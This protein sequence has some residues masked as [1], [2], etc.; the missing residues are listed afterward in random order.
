MFFHFFREDKKL[1]LDTIKSYLISQ[2]VIFGDSNRK[3]KLTGIS[4]IEGEA[5]IAVVRGNPRMG[6]DL[7]FTAELEGIE[8]L[9][10]LTCSVEVEELCDDSAEPANSDISVT[11]LLDTEQGLQ[12][13]DVLGYDNELDVYCKKI[14]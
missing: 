13:K 1:K 4:K 8:Y 9:E 11:T 12:A 7:S 6:Y 14:T 10:G 3:L 5:S 2:N